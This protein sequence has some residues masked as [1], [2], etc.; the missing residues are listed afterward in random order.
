MNA[1]K[2]VIVVLRDRKKDGCLFN[3]IEASSPKVFK[4]GPPTLAAEFLIANAPRPCYRDRSAIRI[5]T[6]Y[7]MRA[8]ANSVALKSDERTAKQMQQKCF[9]VADCLAVT[10]PGTG[11]CVVTFLGTH[12][13]TRQ[14]SWWRNF[15]LHFMP[16]A[17]VHERI[18]FVAYRVLMPK[19]KGNLLENVV[20]LGS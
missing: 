6:D 2:R 16:L 14:S 20:H 9:R 10:S 8:G 11:S 1:P 12:K 15:Y 19:F 3:L 5:L 18:G 17:V 7:L 4:S 13:Q